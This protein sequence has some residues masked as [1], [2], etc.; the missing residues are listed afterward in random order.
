MKHPLDGEHQFLDAKNFTEPDRN[1]DPK[2]VRCKNCGLTKQVILQSDIE[3]CKGKH[4]SYFDKD[5]QTF[6]ARIDLLARLE[7]DFTYHSPKGNQAERYGDHRNLVKLL[8]RQLVMNCPP[9]RELSLALTHLEE[10]VFW[11]NAAI[12]RNE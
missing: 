6:V 8:S 10:A 5:A 2:K 7:N 9:S 1:V 11:S 3:G 4:N 12:A